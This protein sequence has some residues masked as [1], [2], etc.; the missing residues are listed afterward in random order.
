LSVDEDWTTK[1][2]KQKSIITR[3][4]GM[5]IE[6][7]R[8]NTYEKRDKSKGREGYWLERDGQKNHSD[9]ILA[10]TTRIKENRGREKMS[11][12]KTKPRPGYLTAQGEVSVGSSS[13]S[14]EMGGGGQPGV[15][16]IASGCCK[17]RF[18]A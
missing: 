12:T 5:A 11:T 10:A 9:E 15:G 6:Y 2:S 16:G 18:F 8:H 14:E 1:H 7:R 17:R 4:E 3:K 13:I